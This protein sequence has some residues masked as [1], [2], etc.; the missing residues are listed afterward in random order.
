VRIQAAFALGEHGGA[1]D[2]DLLAKSL[3]DA[4]VELRP[5]V[6]AALAM[7]GLDPL[8][9]KGPVLD[10]VQ[11]GRVASSKPIPD[12]AL[13]TD[14]GRRIHLARAIHERD[15]EALLEMAKDGEGQDRIDAIAALGRASGD[16]AIEAL[17]EMAFDKEGTKEDVRKAA[18]RALRRAKRIAD[19][20]EATP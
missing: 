4:N 13:A 19:K 12:G 7:R 1:G 15:L 18:Y 8:G 14:E 17:E 5:A 9:V 6:S 16:E 3:R 10:P 11:L 2:K 20:K